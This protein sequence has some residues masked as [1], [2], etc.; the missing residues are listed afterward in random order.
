MKHNKSF[1]QQFIRVAVTGAIYVSFTVSI[2]DAALYTFNDEWVNWPGYT[3][4]LGDEWGTPKIDHMNVTVNDATGFLENIS[5]VLH[6]STGRQKFDT[7]FINSYNTTTTSS[8]WDDWDYLV[9]DGGRPHYALN[10]TAGAV[11]GDGLYRVATNYDYTFVTHSN[12]V[13]NPN[14]IDA[15]SL[16]LLDNSFGANQNGYTISYDFSSQSIDVSNGFFIAYAPWCDNDV[17]GGGTAAVP[18]PATILLFGAGLAGLMA[19]GRKKR[20]V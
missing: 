8:L 7:L 16:T 10:N 20:M 2:A 5:I 19:A 15:G 17:M 14:G 9:H 3:S 13:G 1:F 18:E 4:S 6:D 12:R 11:P